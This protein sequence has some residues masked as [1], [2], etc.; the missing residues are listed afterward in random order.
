MSTPYKP[1]GYTSA[2]PY[3]IVKDAAGTIAFLQ[4][5]FG[6]EPLRRIDNEDGTIRHSEVRIGDTVVMLADRA[7]GWPPLPAYVH[8]YVPDV[9]AAYQR[10]LA[11]G[12]ESL[13]EPLQKDDPDRRCGV[14]DPGGTT[15]WI[16][17]QMG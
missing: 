8:V 3:L 5:V 14:T 6:A 2:A 11:A 15:W 17:T 4:Q 13:Q 9:D 10:A 1:E 7:E 12:A 16:A